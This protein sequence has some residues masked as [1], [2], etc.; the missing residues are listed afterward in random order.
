MLDIVC[1]RSMQYGV[2]A[3]SLEDARERG[4]KESDRA[5]QR[6]Y[7]SVYTTDN[8]TLIHK[9]KG[10]R[11][12]QFYALVHN[13]KSTRF[14]FRVYLMPTYEDAVVMDGGRFDLDVDK[15]D[16]MKGGQ[17]KTLN[18]LVH[19]PKRTRFSCK[20]NSMPNYEDVVVRID[21][22]FT[23]DADKTDDMKG[24]IK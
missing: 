12:G 9:G 22:R 4:W 23:L 6:G 2:R 24:G 7:V 20:D 11:K 21:G 3:M 5:L 14:C 17:R 16:R 10:K 1:I 19:I 15:A 13:P 8:M 18:V